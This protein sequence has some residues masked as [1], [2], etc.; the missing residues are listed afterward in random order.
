[1]NLSTE[2][3]KKR[4]RVNETLDRLLADCGNVESRLKE[5]IDYA[6]NTPGKRIRA[7]VV[8]WCCQAVNGDINKDGD[9]AAA[10]IEMVHTYSLVHDDLPAMD[11]DNLRRGMPSCHIAFDEATAILTGDALL[12][13]AF[14][15]LAEKIS[16]GELAVEM[17]K[18][19]C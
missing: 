13:F 19:L 3:E 9:I 11:D 4:K 5:A 14:E 12:T 2:L 8:M 17:I 18:R 6:L 7:A 15:V 16:R 1:M 10:A